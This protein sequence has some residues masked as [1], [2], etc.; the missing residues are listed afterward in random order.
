MQLNVATDKIIA[1]IVPA[2]FFAIVSSANQ[3]YY[4][5]QATGSVLGGVSSVQVFLE[6]GNRNDDGLKRLALSLHNISFVV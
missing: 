5:G 1:A 2:T 4:N 3:W 6:Q